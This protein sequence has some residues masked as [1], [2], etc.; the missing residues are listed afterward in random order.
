MPETQSA[1]FNS[2]LTSCYLLTDLEEWIFCLEICA[3]SWTSDLLTTNMV[4]RADELTQMQM[5][6]EMNLMVRVKF[7]LG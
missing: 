5:L 6:E 2:C 4:L 7:R 1:I 3:G